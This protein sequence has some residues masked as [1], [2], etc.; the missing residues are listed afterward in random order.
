MENGFREFDRAL[1]H[2]LWPPQWVGEPPYWER[3][4][5]QRL[6]DPALLG[7]VVLTAELPDGIRVRVFRDGMIAFYM[8]KSTPDFSDTDPALVESFRAW[9]EA[10][11]RLANAHLACLATVIPFPVTGPSG[12]VT[13]WS[14][15]QVDFE[16]GKFEAASH[17]TM[18]G[19]LLALY[20]ARRAGPFDWRFYRGGSL[21]LTKEHLER[22]FDLLR[23][24]LDRPSRE[25]AL[26]RAEMLFRARSGLAHM[27][28][29]GALTSAWGVIE[30]LLGELLRRYLD[31][32]VDRPVDRDTSG[33][34]LKFINSQR[35][36]FL[37]GSEMTARHTLELL[38]L[39]DIL[40]FKLY[41]AS[42]RCAKA[43]ND[44]LHKQQ[45]PSG[46][47]AQMAVR[48]A[49]EL[50]ELVEGVPLYMPP[51]AAG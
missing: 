7:E 33:N 10:V 50:F 36:S 43:R 1:A 5:E 37:E 30:G 2:Y 49:G 32:N 41:L 25:M 22:S 31:E 48:A 4:G 20:D 11:P 51:A 42:T 23:A 18:G 3:T 16:T 12:V 45:E 14:V 38:S 46:E 8:G 6:P 17:P 44:W 35:R 15:M 39:V 34:T 13:T 40:P 47:I 9:H 19:V 28:R 27:D 21:I 24:L 29:A 26:L